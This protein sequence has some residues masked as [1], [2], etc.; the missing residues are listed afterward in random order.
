LIEY[1]SFDSN[2]DGRVKGARKEILQGRGRE[3][4][5]IVIITKPSTGK[6][7]SL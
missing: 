3:G 5:E 7:V 6:A 4:W 1:E 2:D